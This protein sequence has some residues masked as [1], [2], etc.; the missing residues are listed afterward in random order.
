MRPSIKDQLKK[1][2]LKSSVG[3]APREPPLIIGETEIERTDMISSIGHSLYRP[4]T[5]KQRPHRTGRG[6]VTITEVKERMERKPY[7]RDATTFKVLDILMQYSAAPI[8][9]VTKNLPEGTK[10]TTIM[11]G[12]VKFCQAGIAHVKTEGGVKTYCINDAD[13]RLGVDALY[14]KYLDY[15]STVRKPRNNIKAKLTDVTKKAAPAAPST[16]IPSVIEIK[17][18]GT[19]EHIFTFRIGR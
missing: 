13:K 7:N 10:K 18:T 3:E 19:V 15:L 11:S 14:V 5:N 2:G 8:K 4:P 16:N 6:K 1:A 12:L 9:L 17:I